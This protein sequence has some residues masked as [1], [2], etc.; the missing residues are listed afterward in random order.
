MKA[1]LRAPFGVGLVLLGLGCHGGLPATREGR[2]LGGLLLPLT[3]S[4][5]LRLSVSGQVG[6][7]PGEARLEVAQTLS[8]VT[9]ACFQGPPPSSHR[10]VR[11]P[12]PSGGF[13]LL[14][15]VS[16]E[17]ARVG[18]RALGAL[19]VGLERGEG[20]CVL[21]LGADVLSA[22]AL[23]V[24][25]TL[26]TVRFAASV[27][28]AHYDAE[29]PFDAA[30]ERFVIPLARDPKTDWLLAAIRV[31]QQRE[32]VTGPFVV[33]TTLARSVI[34]GRAAREAGMRPWA[35]LPPAGAGAEYVPE[36]T[37]LVPDRVSLLPELSLGWVGFAVA[38]HWANAEALGVLGSDVWEH[39]AFTLDAQALRLEL[40]RPRVAVA[41]GRQ[42]CV[43]GGV[44]SEEACFSVHSRR[45]GRGFE[46]RATLHQDVP[47]GA[48][49]YLEPT[50]GTG[51]MLR[52]LC[53]F[54]MSTGP[55]DRGV[56][57]E[58]RF[59]W[60][61]FEPTLAPCAEALAQAR[62]FRI[63]LWDEGALVQCPG[64][65]AFVEL[66]NSGQTSCMCAAPEGDI[67]GDALFESYR[68]K[69]P[70]GSTP[71]REPARVE[72]EPPDPGR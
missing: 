20:A 17:D 71:A 13:E 16:V 5:L 2:R 7:V 47:I 15:E 38:P 25:P 51:Q 9:R 58:F 63:G 27:A 59:P 70:R 65:C 55:A 6:A 24:D 62:G 35:G 45:V 69:F 11:V 53:R 43:V 1:W 34:S 21:T 32:Q 33:A 18:G 54:G 40:R 36:T 44:A 3:P 50:D 4:P 56:Q 8:T 28:A 26:R 12:R 23:E 41:H 68:Q 42:R 67:E 22:Y 30:M 14:T 48:R 72:P 29:Q 64:T 19:T 37:V 46:A 31:E 10:E 52:S 39:F 61:G 49:V 60:E 66:F 57:M